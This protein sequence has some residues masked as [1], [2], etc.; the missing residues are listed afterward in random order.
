MQRSES[1]T[2]SDSV[3]VKMWGGENRLRY[4]VPRGIAHERFCPRSR[5]H[6]RRDACLKRWNRLSIRACAGEFDDVPPLVGFDPNVPAKI[7]W[8]ADE[9]GATKLGQSRVDLRIGDCRVDL[10]V[11]NI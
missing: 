4:R 3:R 8:S 9:R 11:E 2:I 10:P 1:G 7:G 5:A 6:C